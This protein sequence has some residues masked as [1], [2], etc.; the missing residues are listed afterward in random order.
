MK[1]P[2][3]LAEAST[4]TLI[5]DPWTRD[6]E[7]P[8]QGRFFNLDGPFVLRLKAILKYA[9]AESELAGALGIVGEPATMKIQYSIRCW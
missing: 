8:R 4:A 5:I 1:D 3:F 6:L 9:S 2:K 7:D